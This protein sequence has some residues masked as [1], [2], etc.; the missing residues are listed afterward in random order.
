[1]LENVIANINNCTC[2]P[3][4]NKY[5]WKNKTVYVLALKGP[6]CD[7]KPAYFN[8]E[9]VEFSMDSNYTL[10]QFKAESS[11]LKNIWTCE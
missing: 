8:E 5:L 10:D 7:W 4:I 3:F 2:E 6:E 1:M 9:G 11:F